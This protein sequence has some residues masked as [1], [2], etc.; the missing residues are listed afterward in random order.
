MESKTRSAEESQRTVEEFTR[1]LA[2]MTSAQFDSAAGGNAHPL[3]TPATPGGDVW[4]LA[5]MAY[6]AVLDALPA[7]IAL[8]D[9]E[10]VIL[11]V[12][13]SWRRFG[14]SNGL[15]GANACLGQNYL[16]VCA[17]AEDGRKAAEGIRLVLS[18]GQEGY[19][20][21]Y[22]CHSTEEQRWFRLSIVPISNVV[23]TGAVVMHYDITER[24]L[25]EDAVR[26]AEQKYRSIFENAV[27]GL[28]VSTPEGR[29]ITINPAFAR[30]HGYS[31]PAEMMDACTDIGRQVYVR[32]NRR[33]EMKRLLAECG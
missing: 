2:E 25:A 22:A 18:G 15:Q 6:T 16:E 21:E 28:F 13:A 17:R 29:Y 7:H 8:I 24:R 23:L 30:I 26:V 1:K 27:E 9:R 4:H 33:E 19:T 5:A 20:M 10:G 14:S 3:S 32:T 11:L 12:N 31:S